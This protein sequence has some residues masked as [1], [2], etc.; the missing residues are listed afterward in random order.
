MEQVL[1]IEV[2]VNA[3]V[4]GKQVDDFLRSDVGAYLVECIDKEA[5]EGYDLLKTV[6][7]SNSDAVREAQ[8]RVWRAES[9]KD[10]IRSA[11]MAGLRATEVLESREDD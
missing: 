5:E 3:A 6:S 2:M 9:L 8:N 1:E 10:F 11:V 4:L 7:F